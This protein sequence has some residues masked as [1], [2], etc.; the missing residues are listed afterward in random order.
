LIASSARDARGHETHHLIALQ[1]SEAA[2]ITHTLDAMGNRTG[3]QAFDP[4]GA[5]ARRCTR[6]YDA[7]NRLK[8]DIGATTPA[9]QISP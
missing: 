4:A 2:R 8:Q 5:L 9:T 1:D 3:E 6:V 7:L